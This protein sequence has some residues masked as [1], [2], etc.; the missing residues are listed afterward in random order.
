MLVRILGQ[1]TDRVF[2]VYSICY[3][4][5][6]WLVWNEMMKLGFQINFFTDMPL[7]TQN[8]HISDIASNSAVDLKT[9]LSERKKSFSRNMTAPHVY[10]PWE[11]KQNL[12]VEIEAITQQ[13]LLGII[14]GQIGHS[15]T[16]AILMKKKKRQILYNLIFW[17]IWNSWQKLELESRITVVSHYCLIIRKAAYY[18]TWSISQLLQSSRN[19]Y[20]I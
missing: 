8:C 4:W 13:Y 1:S 18:D 16:T 17:V 12:L 19:L 15:V 6:L 14:G 3:A 7:T 11:N 2:V 10:I 9:S 20:W 5:S